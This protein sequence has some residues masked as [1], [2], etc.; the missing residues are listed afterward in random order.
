MLNN[1]DKINGKDLRLCGVVTEVEHKETKTGKPFG[2]LH[3]EDYHNSFSFYLFGDD[4]INFKAYLTEGWLLHLSGKVKKK[5]YNEDLEFKISSIDLLAE[6]MDKQVRD[7]VLRVDLN[8]ISETLV[9][10]ISTLASKKSG[11]HS[12]VINVVDS[13]NKYE[14]DLLSRKIK[15]NLDKDF[16]TQ[17]NALSQIKMIVK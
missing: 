2:V 12:L 3:L 4:Y 8:D 10:E 17:I 6:I 14:V 1:M 5:F 9:G 13:L 7:I 16:L 11:K 15:V